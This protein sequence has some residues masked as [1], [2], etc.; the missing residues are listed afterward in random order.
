MPLCSFAELN[1]VGLV[2]ILE[3]LYSLV[4]V[5]LEL[6]NL[7]FRLDNFFHFGSDFVEILACKGLL[8]I[9]VVV[10][11]V[12][13]RRTDSAFS[14]RIEALYSLS[15]N[16]RRSMPESLFTVDVVKCEQFNLAVAVK[17]CAQVD[18]TP[19]TLAAHT[20]L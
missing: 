2:H 1:L 4:R 17:R 8:N 5:E 18:N 20:D 15:K 9:E 6:L 13:Y 16:V 14:R 12:I 19:S 11:A 10:E 3:K 7:D